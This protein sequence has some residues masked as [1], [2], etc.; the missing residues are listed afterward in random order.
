MLDISID[1]KEIRLIKY[2]ITSKLVVVENVFERAIGRH[3]RPIWKIE[4]F[5][6]RDG[7]A[8][9]PYRGVGCA[10]QGEIWVAHNA[11]NSTP[12]VPCGRGHDYPWGFRMIGQIVSH[13]KILD[14]LGEGGMGVVYKA[15]DTKL[16]RT[17][18][19][20]FLP[21]DVV[22]VDENRQRFILEAQASAALSHPNIATVFEIGDSESETFIALEYIEGHSLAET[23]KSGPMKLEQAISIAIQTAEG[24][25][26]A[27]ERGVV[28]RDIKCQNIMVTP[29]GQV[30]I[31]DFGLAKLRGASIVT[32]AG[33][34]LGT[35]DY[36]SPEQLRGEPVDHRTDIWAL[37]VVL[38]EV[39]TGRKPFRGD[40]DNAVAYQVLNGQLEPITAIRTG[41]PM[42]LER[43]VNKA[44]QKESAERY[45]HVDEM[46]V[47][48]RSLR[49]EAGSGESNRGLNRPGRLLKK[50]LY[51]YGG[52]AAFG[53]LVVVG[54][55]LFQSSKEGQ[56]VSPEKGER[57]TQESGPKPANSIAVLPFRNISSDAEQEYFCD[58]LTEQVITTLSNLRDLKVIARTSVMQFKNSEKAIPEIGRQLGVAN[59][60]EGSI[61]KSGNHIRITAK[62]IKA[63]DGFHLWAEDYDRELKDVF[64]VQDD[65][66]RSIVAA[67]RL[68]LSDEQRSAI[69]KRYTE[70]TRAYGMY[71]RG[72]FHLNK[73]TEQGFKSAVEFFERAIGLDSHY[74]LAYSGLADA[75]EM[76]GNHAYLQPGDAFPKARAAA[77]KALELDDGIGEAHASLGFVKYVYELDW[78]GAEEAFRR[79]IESNPSYPRAHQ[80]YSTFLLTFLRFDEALAEAQ[81]AQQL[82]PLSVPIA[83]GVGIAHTHARQYDRAVEALLGVAE[84][85]PNASSMYLEL[86]IAYR[87]KGMYPEA[88][89]NLQ[90]AVGGPGRTGTNPLAM[91][92]YVHGEAGQLLHARRILGQLQQESQDRYI[93]PTAFALVYTGLGD[94]DE[95]MSWLEK[96]YREERSVYLTHLDVE[97]TWDPLRSNPRFLA[98]LERMGLREGRH[99]L[100]L[101]SHRQEN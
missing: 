59:V 34:I 15:E 74:S 49:N 96:A 70:N 32:K 54:F 91:L 61:R 73:G 94:Y 45:Q 39:V 33:T 79:A 80:W 27:H 53:V 72:R 9:S 41:V 23:V 71:L 21:R 82:D 85:D 86:G 36:M 87:G 8:K 25:Q 83:V 81:H 89:A 3:A 29:R 31:L 5:R 42:E 24:L 30:K 55:F 19:V 99:G 38:F 28:H 101:P 75:Y 18:A 56:S 65:V 62:L 13:Y 7:A 95:A 57:T 6:D 93:Q 98:L 51:L 22:A 66:A 50:H 14:K 97:P 4:G 76:L 64:V 90:R 67:M 44:L 26:A 58:G 47:D 63:D 35:I 48:L 46:L 69:T 92:G 68:N 11:R 100:Q 60:L 2:G 16:R 52:I 40:Y 88:I 43:I 78:T 1:G 12:D 37:G 84:L 17:V 10:G 20:K 77:L